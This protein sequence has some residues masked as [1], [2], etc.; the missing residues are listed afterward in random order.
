MSSFILWAFWIGQG[1]RIT[2]GLQELDT[3]KEPD[4]F[5]PKP[6]AATSSTL[7]ALPDRTNPATTGSVRLAAIVIEP[8]VSLVTLGCRCRPDREER[9]LLVRAAK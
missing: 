2:T 9:H 4:H 6:S 5:D 7:S 1:T 8:G 3:I